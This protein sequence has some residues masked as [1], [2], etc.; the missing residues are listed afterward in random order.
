MLFSLKVVETIST[1]LLPPLLVVVTNQVHQ[2]QT[3]QHQ[4]TFKGGTTNTQPMVDTAKDS[5]WSRNGCEE[6]DPS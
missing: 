1:M 2:Q 6:W 4:I 5:F 3:K